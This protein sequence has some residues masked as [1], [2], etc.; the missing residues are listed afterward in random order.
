MRRLIILLVLLIASVWAGLHVMHHSGYLFIVYEPWT[1]QIP[2]WFALFSVFIVLALLYY[3]VTSIDSL[4]FM[5]YRFK[6]WLRFRREHRAYSKT[7]HGLTLL[8]EGQWKKSEKLLLSGVQQETEPFI[9]Y[10]SIATIAE[11]Q[12][13]LEKANRYLDKASQLYGDAE[14]AVNIVRAKWQLKHNCCDDAKLTLQRLKAL[15]PNHPEVLKLHERLF[16]RQGQL[17]QL[18]Q[19]IPQLLKARVISKENAISLRQHIAVERLS[20]DSIDSLAALRVRFQELSRAER[21][22][23]MIACAYIKRLIGFGETQAAEELIRQTLK[24]HWNA[25]LVLLYS[26]LPFAVLNKQYV[27]VG[28]WLK[29]HGQQPESYLALARLCMRG[30]LWGKAKDYFE[31]CLQLGPNRDASLELGELYEQLGESE[32]A[33]EAYQAG[34]AALK[35]EM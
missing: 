35:V 31:K 32:L 6:N 13:D 24:S 27:I 29:Q 19:L 5:W 8:L 14:L 23:P 30:Q 2:L 17:E 16:V 9:N 18:E 25:E 1:V 3:L 12:N 21:S 11:K 28:A 26:K 20:H 4:Q 7:R 33:K 34:L 15:S 22:N 10:M